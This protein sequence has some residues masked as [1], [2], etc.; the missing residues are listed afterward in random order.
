MEKL[1][2]GLA[3]QYAL[4]GLISPSSRQ[5]LYPPCKEPEALTSR[6]LAPEEEPG[7]TCPTRQRCKRAPFCSSYVI[8]RLDGC[9]FFFLWKLDLF[10]A[11]Y[12]HNDNAQQGSPTSPLS[13]R[14]CYS[15]IIELLSRKT[16]YSR[17]RIK[18][19]ITAFLFITID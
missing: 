10:N 7:L 9:F 3:A 8:R 18:Q 13:E 2:S 11:S 5:S 6:A 1:P 15:E 4:P 19:F 14:M 16:D 12:T 17:P